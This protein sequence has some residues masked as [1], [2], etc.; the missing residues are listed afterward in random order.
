MERIKEW[1][2]S[3]FW[4][5][6]TELMLNFSAVDVAIRWRLEGTKPLKPVHLNYAVLEVCNDSQI[7]RKVLIHVFKAIY[8]GFK[9]SIL[10]T[11][12]TS[13][14]VLVYLFWDSASLL[15]FYGQWILNEGNEVSL[16]LNMDVS[17]DICWRVEGTKYDNLNPSI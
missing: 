5:L 17:M 1:T 16:T 3:D 14:E 9:P 2:D 10:S 4:R 11:A 12:S 7:P 15:L 8:H 6:M 13:T